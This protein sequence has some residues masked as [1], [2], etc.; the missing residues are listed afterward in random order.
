MKCC[1]PAALSL[2]VSATFNGPIISPYFCSQF[3]L[4]VMFP[5]CITPIISAIGWSIRPPDVVGSALSFTTILPS[6]S[7]ATLAAHLTELNHVVG[8]GCCRVARTYRAVLR[9]SF[10]YKVATVN[11]Q[12]KVVSNFYCC[13]VSQETWRALSYNVIN[14]RRLYWRTKPKVDKTDLTRTDP[15]FHTCFT[16]YRPSYTQHITAS[17]HALS[18]KYNTWHPVAWN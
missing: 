13:T 12:L 1:L 16:I 4:F 8:S 14:V 7:S 6:Y 5:Y 9:V 10:Y 3:Y 17:N 2:A 11:N 18:I 15:E